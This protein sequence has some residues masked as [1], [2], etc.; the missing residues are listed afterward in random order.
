MKQCVAGCKHFEGGEIKHH[1]DCDF[2]PDSLSQYYDI[3]FDSINRVEIINHNSS[4]FEIGRIFTFRG[5][6]ETSLQDD[7]KTLKIFI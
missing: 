3:L 7:N 5:K 6:I 4:Q 1:K 2:Y